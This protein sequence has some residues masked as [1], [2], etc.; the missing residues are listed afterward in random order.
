MSVLSRIVLSISLL[1]AAPVLAGG[2]T[3][4]RIPAEFGVCVT[5]IESG[6][7]SRLDSYHN[8]EADAK[9]RRAEILKNGWT[10]QGDESDREDE[11][12]PHSIVKATVDPTLIN[13]PSCVAPQPL[14]LTPRQGT[15]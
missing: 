4:S 11:Y 2:I 8:T 10:T 14:A 3:D 7:R 13:L 9:A 5:T 6:G 1:A 15:R 12:P